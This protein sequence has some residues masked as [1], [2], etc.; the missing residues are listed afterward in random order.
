MASAPEI[1]IVADKRVP[2]DDVIPDH[3]GDYTGATALMEVRPE[4]GADGTPVLSLSTALVSG[5]G[6]VITYDDEYVTERNGTI[7]TGASLVQ[8]LINETTLE[9]IDY[10]ASPD[11]R[12]TYHYDMHITPSGGKKFVAYRGTFTIAPGVV[13]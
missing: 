13:R 11:E 1:N 2:F 8:I 9:A 3:R 10:A 12:A 5:E 4:P 6:I 7:Y